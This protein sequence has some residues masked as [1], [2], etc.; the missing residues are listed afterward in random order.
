MEARTARRDYRIT[1][2]IEGDRLV[3]DYQVIRLD[4]GGSYSGRSTLQRR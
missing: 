1:G 4:S 2:R 3:L